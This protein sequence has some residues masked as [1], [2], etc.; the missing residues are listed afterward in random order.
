MAIFTC[1]LKKL[2][3][4]MDAGTGNDRKGLFIGLQ[5]SMPHLFFWGGVS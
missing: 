2:N 3:R 5:T 1:I 4:G